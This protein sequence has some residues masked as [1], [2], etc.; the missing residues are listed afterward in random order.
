MAR[1]KK[2]ISMYDIIEEL[3]KDAEDWFID[4]RNMEPKDRQDFIES[5]FEDYLYFKD[6]GSVFSGRYEKLLVHLVKTYGH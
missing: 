5:V 2:K 3:V 4:P 6:R 1:S